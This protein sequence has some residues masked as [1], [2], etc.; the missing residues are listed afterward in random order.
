MKSQEKRLGL[1]C[2]CVLSLIALP[3]LTGGLANHASCLQNHGGMQ[4]G[5]N[6]S[7]DIS[8]GGE[9]D[10]HESMV[11]SL[12]NRIAGKH[13][14]ACLPESFCE[15]VF[16]P[17]Q[18]GS[19]QCYAVEGFV[20]LFWDKPQ[21]SSLAEVWQALERSGWKRIGL[22]DQSSSCIKDTGSYRWLN[23]GVFCV[24][25]CMSI[26]LNYRKEA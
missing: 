12:F 25:G 8:K 16:D 19:Y 3:G 9:T 15:E 22:T 1:A 5:N 11:E 7:I 6:Q 10:I 18:W 26:N 21:S 14:Q 13:Y 17:G 4:H 20:G 2:I 23:V 24:N